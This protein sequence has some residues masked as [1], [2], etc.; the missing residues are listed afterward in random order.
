MCLTEPVH[1][2]AVDGP[3]ATV[4]ANGRQR[5]VSAL[6]V[7]EVRAG[8]WAILAAGLLVRVLTP[9]TAARMADARQLA[10]D[11]QPKGEPA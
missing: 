5:T 11:D 2:L 9:E 6:A 8:D 3:I 4:E 1:V 10:A 7:P